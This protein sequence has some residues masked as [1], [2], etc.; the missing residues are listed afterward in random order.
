MSLACC[1]V[2]TEYLIHKTAAVLLLLFIYVYLFIFKSADRD[3]IQGLVPTP[4]GKILKKLL[5]WDIV[6]V[7]LL[8]KLISVALTSGPQI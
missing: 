5:E 6:K 1:L 7:T 4:A 8:L 2:H 3:H